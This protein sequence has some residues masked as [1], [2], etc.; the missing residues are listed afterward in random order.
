MKLTICAQRKATLGMHPLPRYPD[1]HS[2]YGVGVSHTASKSALSDQRELMC[3]KNSTGHRSR[4][5][6]LALLPRP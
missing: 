1:N 3:P 4:R 5:Y 6:F 2:G